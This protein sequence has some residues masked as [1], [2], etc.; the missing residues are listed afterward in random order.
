MFK[1]EIQ[2]SGTRSRTASGSNDTLNELASFLPKEYL[3][4][5]KTKGNTVTKSY[6]QLNQLDTVY[7]PETLKSNTLCVPFQNYR[8]TNS[9]RSSIKRCASKNTKKIVRFA[10]SLGLD[11]EQTRQVHSLSH[12]SQTTQIFVPYNPFSSSKP[13]FVPLFLLPSVKKIDKLLDTTHV[14]LESVA[15]GGYLIKG[16]EHVNDAFDFFAIATS[17]SI[18]H[19]IKLCSFLFAGVIK[20]KNLTFEKKITVRYTVD[21]WKTFTDTE[22]AYI[23]HASDGFTDKFSFT[24][25]LTNRNENSLKT[26]QFAIRYVAANVGEFWDSNNSLNYHF[27]YEDPSRILETQPSWYDDAWLHFS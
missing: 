10:D 22:A 4:L 18:R 27:R 8:R 2:R 12:S 6:E 1:D 16:K 19:L 15:V 17:S 5:S 7:N 23:R 11:L 21:D 25:D 14:C 20:V 9:L 24:I 13:R 3:N 26:L